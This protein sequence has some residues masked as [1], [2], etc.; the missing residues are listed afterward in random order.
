MP[1]IRGIN[2]PRE[3]DVKNLIINGNFDVWQ[4]G[5]SV[6]ATPFAYLAD[7]WAYAAS[8]ALTVDIDRSTDVPNDQALFSYEISRAASIVPA[9][10]ELAYIRY[11][12]EGRDFNEIFDKKITINFKVKSTQTGTYCVNLRNG[13]SD[14]IYIAEYTIDAADTWEEKSIVVDMAPGTASG[15]WEKD[16]GQGLQ[17][18]FELSVGSDFHGTAGSWQNANLHSTANQVNLFASAS[19]SFKLSQVQVVA[20]VVAPKFKSAGSSIE[21]EVAK[22]QR[23]YCLLT[24]GVNGGIKNTHMNNYNGVLSL[25]DLFFPVE[26]RTAPTMSGTFTGGSGQSFTSITTMGCYMV[27]TGVAGVFTNAGTATADAEF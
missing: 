7:R 13:A 11:I 5:T 23:Y 4:R 27:A 3:D 20:G 18:R 8:P 6:S 24:G 22:C 17:V 1:K 9:N 10:N 14:R 16:T 25:S 15:T 21:D 12:L 26:M 2:K 19:S